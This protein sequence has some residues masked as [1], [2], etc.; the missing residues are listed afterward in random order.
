MAGA[1]QEDHGRDALT[2]AVDEVGD[3][4][5]LL[6]APEEALGFPLGHE[7]RLSEDPR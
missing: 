7:H 1:E 5:R 2:P 4:S 6:V 3:L